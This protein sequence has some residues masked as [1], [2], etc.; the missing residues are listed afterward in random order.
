MD[1]QM[2]S[3][4]AL[5]FRKQFTVVATAASKRGIFQGL[6]NAKIDVVLL[7]AD[8]QDKRMAGLKMLPKLRASH[9]AT[10]IIMLLDPSQNHL[11]VQSFCSGARG[12]FCRSE[13]NRNMLR[14]S[15]DAVYKGK[16]WAN[17]RQLQVLLKALHSSAPNQSFVASKKDRLT[18]RAQ[19]I[20]NLVGEGLQMHEVAQRLGISEYTVSND[21]F[22]I[23]DKSGFSRTAPAPRQDS[24]QV[25]GRALHECGRFHN[26]ES[27]QFQ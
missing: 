17:S 4:A 12:V 24:R 11:A 23:Y 16:A 1:C 10:Q 9:P 22:T 14:E 21:L 3:D 15:I 5:R 7:S 19:D 25:K 18:K 6:A 26:C 8:L 20:A 2:L 13:T 27:T